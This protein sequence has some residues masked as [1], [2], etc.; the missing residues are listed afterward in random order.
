MLT[1]LFRPAFPTFGI[2][3]N[4]LFLSFCVRPPLS[5]SAMKADRFFFFPFFSV[6][7]CVLFRR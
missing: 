6:C 1:G 7:S 4:L 3:G 5:S 2:G